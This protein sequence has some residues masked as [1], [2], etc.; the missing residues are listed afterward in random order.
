MNTK[1]T[2]I[3]HLPSV[4]IITEADKINLVTTLSKNCFRIS[5]QYL[6]LIINFGAYQWYFNL[7]I[8]LNDANK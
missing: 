8:L 6:K 4:Q 7:V 2:F 5:P 1:V 3:F